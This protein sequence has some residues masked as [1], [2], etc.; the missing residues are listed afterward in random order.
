MT[1]TPCPEPDFLPRPPRG[2]R[3]AWAACA[4]ATLVLGVSALD[5][6]EAWQAR[7]DALARLA[8]LQARTHTP[9]ARAATA[10]P[11]Q[12]LSPVA[13][14]LALPWP[15]LF[16]LAESA[17]LP[18][19]QWL[20]LDAPA[21]RPELRLEGLVPDAAVASELVGALAR[22]P[23]WH[24]VVL[25]RLQRDTGGGVRFEIG[26]RRQN[27]GDTAPEPRP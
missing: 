20:L 18:G 5:A 16:A 1:G 26:A 14:R 12:A 19:V 13:A 2:R 15:Q 25:T 3:L 8:A 24:D 6:R 21:E 9:A 4:T 7:D 11:P 17:S 27:A 22:Q 10:A 23:G